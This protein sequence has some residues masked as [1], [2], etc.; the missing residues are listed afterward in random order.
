MTTRLKPILELL[1]VYKPLR[2]AYKRFRSELDIRTTSVS[3]LKQRKL[4]PEGPFSEMLR[5]CVAVLTRNSGTGPIGDYLEFGVYNGTSLSC[6]YAVAEE[7]GLGPMNF[8]GFDSFEGLPRRANQDDEGLWVEGQYKCSIEATREN[9]TDRGVDWQRVKLI[10]GWFSDTLTKAV[11]ERYGIE[12][13]AI[14]MVDCDN[15]ASAAEALHFVAPLI[16]D[17]AVIL[18]DDWRAWGLDTRN[19]GEKRAFSKFLAAHPDFETR[20]MGRYSDDSQVFHVR[21][22]SPGTSS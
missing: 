18:F 20:D 1:G 14:V 16:S 19:L 8:Y 10:K 4:V 11:V 5:E 9:L 2:Y 7:A 6:M 21:R 15:Y 22:T 12:K 13:A 3:A 17:Q